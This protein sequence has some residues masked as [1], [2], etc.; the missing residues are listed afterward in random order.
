MLWGGIAGG[1]LVYGWKQKSG[2][3]LAAG[4]AMTAMSFIGPNALI[5][6]LV[7]IAIMVATWWAMKRF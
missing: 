4:A 1:Y 3:P 5:M 2:Y 7:C 6:S